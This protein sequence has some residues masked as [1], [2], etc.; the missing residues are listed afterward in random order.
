MNP[1]ASANRVV[2]VGGGLAGMASAAALAGAGFEVDLL[3]RR[4][5]LGGRATSYE[6]P[7]ARVPGE[8]ID[9]C[10]HV[11]LGCCT[12]LLDFYSRLGV[13][14]CIRFYDAVTFVTP[15]GGCSEMRAG[16]LP[17]PLHLFGSLQ[18]LHALTRLDKLSISAGMA[19]LSFEFGM[20]SRAQLDSETMMSWLVRH[21]QTR[22]A[23]DF[24]WRVILTS[25]LNENLERVSAWQG[26]QVLWKGFLASRQAWLVGLPAVPLAQ[27]YRVELPGV[28]V[29]FRTRVTSLTV[30][31]GRVT[32]AGTAAGEAV[33][34]SWFVVALPFEDAGQFVPGDFSAFTHSPIVGIH[35]WFDRPVMP[36]PFAALLG[37][38]IQWAF[39]R[40]GDDRGP[41]GALPSAAGWD[42]GYIQCVVSAARA[43]VPL[44]RSEI[45]EM[46]VRELEEFF[47]GHGAHL[48]K[49]TVVKE[50]HA[51]Y[52]AAPG[53]EL[54]RPPAATRC[55]NLFLA[56]DWTDN[57]W[58][59][60]M[61]AAVRS[62]YR[63][64]E[65]VAARAGR[66][67]HFLRPEL[68]PEG[69]SRWAPAAKSRC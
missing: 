59:P 1:P 10:Q 68:K 5:F 40:S 4:P 13:G 20:T 22:R 28:R 64:A 19:A 56:G 63:A 69:L 62:G 30:S 53:M 44:S 51:T 21:R 65:L 46:A 34:G 7:G 57:G 6:V 33:P 52:S 38:T 16:S 25:A 14:D 67:R 15:G 37:R 42:E 12:N 31:A 48:L 32:A 3:E 11:L 39:R 49:A 24:F 58:P 55:E 23:I 41:R 50:L 9:N 35:L 54:A 8:T 61:E 27:L 45:I 36:Q 60:T 2:V 26:L 29:H 18:R 43:L 66:P 47:P 17:A